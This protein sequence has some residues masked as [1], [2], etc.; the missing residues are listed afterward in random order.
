MEFN[1]PLTLNYFIMKEEHP[2]PGRPYTGIKETA[3]LPDNPEGKKVIKY[4]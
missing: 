3:Y 2:H 4:S 1:I